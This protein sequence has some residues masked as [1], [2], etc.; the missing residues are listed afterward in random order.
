M[1]IS[2]LKSIANDYAPTVFHEFTRKVSLTTDGGEM[3]VEAT[4]EEVA[5]MQHF[6]KSF[7]DTNTGYITL[8]SKHMYVSSG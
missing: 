3:L 4:P 6:F 5:S 1:R 2:A 8:E 7:D